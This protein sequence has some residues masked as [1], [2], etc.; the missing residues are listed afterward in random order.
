MKLKSILAIALIILLI[1]SFIMPVSALSTLELYSQTLQQIDGNMCTIKYWTP[2]DNYKNVVI[3]ESYPNSWSS[4]PSGYQLVFYTDTTK[5]GMYSSNYWMATENIYYRTFK[6]YEEAIEALFTNESTTE[7]TAGTAINYTDTVNKITYIN[8]VGNYPKTALYQ[9]DLFANES[10]ASLEVAYYDWYVETNGE[11]PE[12]IENESGNNNSS[13]GGGGS[14]F[15]EEAKLTLWDYLTGIFDG[16][17]DLVN[18]FKWQNGTLILDKAG[19]LINEKLADNKFYTSILSVRNTLTDLFN[20]DYTSRTGFYELGLTNITLGQTQTKVYMDFGND[21]IGEF[22]QEYTMY[23]NIDYGLDNVKVLNLDWYFGKDYGNGY[24]T[25]GMKP[26][27]DTFISGFLWLIFAWGL[28]RNMPNWISGE[29]TQISN[30]TSQAV[31]IK[32][33]KI[34]T[35]TT[36]K[37]GK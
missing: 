7:Y 5:W 21:T 3:F 33:R 26:Y 25:K 6:T 14:S 9:S 35:D 11:E 22:E 31:S 17:K 4:T 15:D 23:G 18:I 34:K 30:L 10:A 2:N 36:E 28:Y 13:G 27:V 24:Y 32:E 20:E 19:E 16:I 12:F 37:K 29:I 1:S 8:S